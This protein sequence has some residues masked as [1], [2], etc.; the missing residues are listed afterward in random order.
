MW[1]RCT[2]VPCHEVCGVTFSSLSSPT[3]CI[4]LDEDEDS[5]DELPVERA[6]RELEEQQ[7]ED[8]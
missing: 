5:D 7:A 3:A 8:A 4:A 6:A 2:D 1:D